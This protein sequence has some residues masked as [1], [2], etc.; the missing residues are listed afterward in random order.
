MR[1]IMFVLACVAVLF[2]VIPTPAL[3]TNCGQA[4][5]A[6]VAAPVYSTQFL[7]AQPQFVTQLVAAPVRVQRQVQL[8]RAPAFQRQVNIVRQR[9]FIS[10]PRVQRFIQFQRVGGFRSS[11][12]QFNSGFNAG[13]STFGGFPRSSAFSFQSGFG[14]PFGTSFIRTSSFGF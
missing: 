7:V 10:A 5:Q 11:S 8:V 14:S 1:S 2:L 9:Q 4:V 13:F 12:L 6:V 3:A